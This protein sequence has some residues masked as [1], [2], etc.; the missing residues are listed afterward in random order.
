MR[1]LLL[2]RGCPASGKSTY[3]KENNLEQYTL[4]ADDLRIKIQSPVLTEDGT[5]TI[6][7]KRDFEV[8]KLLF[9]LMEGKM[10]KGEFIVIDATNNNDK[11]IKQYVQYAK[12]YKYSVF[13]KEMDTPLE[14]CLERNSLRDEYK[15][16]PEEVIHRH[17][18]N[19]QLS[20]IPSFC[21]KIKGVE[22]INNFYVEDLSEYEKL[23]I[24][25]DV[26][27]CYEPLKQLLDEEMSDTTAFIFTGDYIDRGI[28]NKEVMESLL[29]LYIKPNFF[30]L[31]GNHDGVLLPLA[32]G[33]NSE[34]GS[35]EKHTRPQLETI[36][37]KE[38]KGFYK[39]LRQCMKVKFHNHK[40]LVTHGGLP[41]NPK[42]L[43]YV[44]TEQLIK[45]V[46]GYEFDIDLAYHNNELNN[47][48][49]IQI[50]G[51][52]SLEKNDTLTSISLEDSVEFGGNLKY[53]VVS[54]EGYVVK[55]IKNTVFNENV[56]E[57]TSSDENR[58]GLTTENEEVNKISKSRFVKVKKLKD[59]IASINFTRNAFK[60]RAWDE[61]TIKARGLFVDRTTGKV[62]A[63]SFNKFFNANE[64]E[65]TSKHSLKKNLQYPVKVYDKENGYLGIISHLNG[66]LAFYTKSVN[67][68]EM[69]D[70]FKD[71]FYKS[72]GDKK[73]EFLDL[74]IKND[75]S[76]VFEV[77]DNINDPHIIEVSKEPYITLLETFRNT[78]EAEKGVVYEEI[79]QCLSE[80]CI[81]DK[82]L[83]EVCNNFEEV[84]L[85]INRV[86]GYYT[87]GGVFEDSNGFM[88][89]VKSDYYNE[90][91][92]VRYLITNIDK[93]NGY[94]EI[95]KAN[96]ETQAKFGVWYAKNFELVKGKNL[97]ELRKLFL[98][99]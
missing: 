91:K 97:L 54:K 82:G 37:K 1:T 60:K 85:A 19:I 95:R 35:F 43:T 61:Q 98:D 96:T 20:K 44:A 29:E 26:H 42:Q 27:G 4:S 53:I 25:G 17:F 92:Q 8:W 64:L 57:F 72:I 75:I 12:E 9:S 22:E 10:K 41:I 59:N 58:R 74:I 68:S 40:F 66:E 76:V 45:G 13:I 80:V 21:K 38:L 28:Q 14:V 84:E 39:K 94:F 71:I 36:N 67:E 18:R 86:R 24:V 3:I 34:K 87:E 93:Q 49:F 69:V 52:R 90:W 73:K 89:K 77:V 7:Q 81:W 46:G 16:V 63:R 70:M 78:L 30:F 65:S 32:L 2:M 6:T 15:R 47:D 62:V 50:H 5:F 83:I 51:H 79:K 56:N 99:K 55:T 11:Q 48:G 23:V 88:F 31:E 33:V